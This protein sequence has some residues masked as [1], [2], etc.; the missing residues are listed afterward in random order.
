MPALVSLSITYF[1]K[2]DEAK[3]T[4][5]L[6]AYTFSKVK[7]FLKAGKVSGEECEEVKVKL[8]LKSVDED[9]INFSNSDMVK[10][11]ANVGDLVYLT[12]ARNW[13]GGLKSIHYIYG[14]PHTE[15]GIVYITN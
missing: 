12:D 8:K 2:Y 5:G 3:N 10:M 9:V 1:V 13:L 14:E 6:T 11:K 7:E 4:K 15:D